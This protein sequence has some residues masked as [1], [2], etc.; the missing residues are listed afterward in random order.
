[1]ARRGLLAPD[2]QCAPG[3]HCIAHQRERRV[4]PE[5]VVPLA[6]GTARTLEQV[7]RDRIE[8]L[9]RTARGG[10]HRFHDVAYH[11]LDTRVA[12]RAARERSEWAATPGHDRR[13]DLG[14]AP[15]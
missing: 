13:L 14:D 1:E 11:D 5:R 3:R 8:A 2:P 6:A 10:A 9:E 7:E 15:R 12:A 4:A